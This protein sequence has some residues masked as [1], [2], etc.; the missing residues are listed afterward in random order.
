MFKV[1]VSITDHLRGYAPNMGK[2][3]AMQIYAM[4]E[5]RNEEDCK[6]LVI[7]FLK[8]KLVRIFEAKKL[9][10]THY[11]CLEFAITAHFEMN[12]SSL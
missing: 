2:Y 3:K 11:Q 6:F 12:S 4:K 7:L 5:G 8:L 10:W 1:E 9:A